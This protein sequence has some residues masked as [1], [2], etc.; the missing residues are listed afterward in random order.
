MKRKRTPG[1]N[2]FYRHLM[3]LPRE[4]ILFIISIMNTLPK[5]RVVDQSI[6]M[7][8]PKTTLTADEIELALASLF[9][10]KKEEPNQHQRCRFKITEENRTSPLFADVTVFEKD[11]K[12][13]IQGKGASAYQDKIL[14]A[15]FP[16]IKEEVSALSHFFMII[17]NISRK[18]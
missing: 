5:K 12:V 10:V 4:L 14:A 7:N 2:Y 9:T 6:K 17:Y 13:V 1:D 18:L 15:L 8:Q 16:P 3:D 11:G